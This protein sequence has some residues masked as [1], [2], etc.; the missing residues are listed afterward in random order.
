MRHLKRLSLITAGLLTLSL[1]FQNC[2]GSFNQGGLDT[3]SN[4]GADSE[5]GSNNPT[6]IGGPTDS[7]SQTLPPG[8]FQPIPQPSNPVP[9]SQGVLKCGMTSTKSNIFVGQ[10]SLSWSWT[11]SIMG[12]SVGQSNTV[13]NFNNEVI[14]RHPDIA[15]WG[16]S[17]GSSMSN[18]KTVAYW[19][20]PLLISQSSIR[21]EYHL[22][23]KTSS[24]DWTSCNTSVSVN[25]SRR[26]L[27]EGSCRVPEGIEGISCGSAGTQVFLGGVCLVTSSS[28]NPNLNG[29]YF[30]CVDTGNG[31]RDWQ[32]I[33]L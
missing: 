16:I 6:D 18:P 7:P 32:E 5:D 3:R 26:S 25:F 30:E 23:E 13:Y 19:I 11:S 8:S 24:S 27:S 10:D 15:T 2:G 9:P 14:A 17:P 22:H 21:V 31:A 12:G 29:K 28:A 33:T 4:A 1:T 20:T